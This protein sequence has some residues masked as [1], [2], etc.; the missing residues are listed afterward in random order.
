MKQVLQ[1]LDT[2]ETLLV[3]GPT[4]ALAPARVLVASRRSLLSVG[5]ERS[6]LQFGQANLLQKALQQPD[7]VKQVLTRARAD[8]WLSTLEA[9]RAKL[10]QPI[11]MGYCN[12]GIVIGVGPGVTEFEVGQ[13]VV[14]NGPHAEVVSVS[15]NLCAKLPDAVSFDDAPF[16]VLGAVALQGIRLLQPALGECFVVSGLG[17]IGLLAVQLL[18]AHG[19]RV[20]GADVDAARCR[21]AEALGA[22]AVLLTDSEALLGAALR[23]SG[24]RGVDGVLVTASTE[25]SDPINQGARA[26]RKRGRIVQVGATGLHVERAE[27]YAK[28]LSLQVAC[29]YGPGRYDPEYEDKG[30]DYP[31]GFVRFTARRNF[32]VVLELMGERKLD[33]ARLISHRFSIDDAKEA[34]AALGAANCRGVLLEYGGEVTRFLEPEQRRVQVGQPRLPRVDHEP[35]L[36][37]LGAGNYTQRTLLPALSRCGVPLRRKVIVSQG[38]LSSVLAARRFGFERAATDER[39]VLDDA[40]IDTVLITSQHH[41]H[42]EQVLRALRAG[43]HVFV[44]KPLCLTVQ[45]CEAIESESAGR[46]QLLSVG[47]NRRFAPLVLEMRRLLAT[48]SAPKQLVYL[49]N[50]GALPSGHWTRDPKRGGGRL[51]GEACHFIDLLRCLANSPIRRA[52]K[53]ARPVTEEDDGF[54]VSLLFENGSSAVLHYLA[55]GHRSFP[56]E[57]LTVFSAGRVLELDNFRCLRGFGWPGVST[58]RLLKQDKGHT[59][60]MKAFFDAL[61]GKAP[62]PIPLDEVFEIS[63]VSCALA[64]DEVWPLP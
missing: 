14:C 36:G 21:E 34:Y 51:V 39:E 22:E 15:P 20:L 49:V 28:E 1:E 16:A 62:A 38:G 41:L 4:P 9:V 55:N 32:E 57:R 64:T 24:G 10:G 30:H 5:T 56:K 3:E 45:D 23:F 48:Q 35:T 50:A 54:E 47:F 31:I 63:R 6:L 25:S 42:A 7:R 33:V 37:V 40:E 61:V 44:E 13:R 46:A 19:A 18:Q 59:A 11:T 52:T 2:G 60:E 27:F 58:R 12:A 29:S 17:L 53:T 43:K 8:G 26:C